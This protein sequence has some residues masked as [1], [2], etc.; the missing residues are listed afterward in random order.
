MDDRRILAAGLLFLAWAL[1]LVSPVL[2]LGW[3]E[4]TRGLLA[5]LATAAI[6]WIPLLATS[7]L[8]AAGSRVAA[9]WAGGSTLLIPVAMVLSYG[10]GIGLIW[11]LV[12]LFAWAAAWALPP[13]ESPVRAWAPA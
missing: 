5:G 7:I 12:G 1:F 3:D 4:G 13:K 11:I 2:F 10:S 8:V 6:L 9:L